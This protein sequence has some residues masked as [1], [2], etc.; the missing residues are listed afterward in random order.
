MEQDLVVALARFLL[1]HE[2]ERVAQR[3]DVGFDRGLDVLALQLEAVDLALD[4][5]EARLRLLEQQIGAAFR[6]A[7]D[8]PRLVLGVGLDVVRQLLRRH[9]RVLQVLLVL[10]VLG[11]HRLHAHQIL[12]QAVGL[13][14]RLLVVVGDRGEKRGDLDRVET[15]ESLAKTLLA[16]VKRADIHT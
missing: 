2:V 15:A 14:Q 3:R 9:Q 5:L 11:E 12:A 4:V 1:A 13:A 10:A 7:D 16:K 8:A 6:L